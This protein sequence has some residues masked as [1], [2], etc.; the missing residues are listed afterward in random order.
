[1]G[2]YCGAAP[3]STF[4]PY[5]NYSTSSLP[6]DFT[7]EFQNLSIEDQGANQYQAV[8]GYYP[9]Y[10]GYAPQPIYAQPAPGYYQMPPVPQPNPG[11]PKRKQP[12]RPSQFRPPSSSFLEK[13]HDHGEHN[14]ENEEAI[15]ATIKEFEEKSSDFSLLKGKVSELA[16]SQ[17]GSRFLQK[18]L[19]KAS[20]S[21]ISFVLGEVLSISRI[22][23]S[24]GREDF[25]RFDGR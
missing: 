10:M 13:D 24:I 23:L 15:I 16:M 25:A 2:Y 19:T 22:K 20:P 3:P 12:S 17:T 14:A 7:N 4:G 9:V 18:Q 6:Q 21:F 11:T 8:P 5:G 1:M